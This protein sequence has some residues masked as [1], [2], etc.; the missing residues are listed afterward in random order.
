MLSFSTKRI[1]WYTVLSTIGLFSLPSA[2]LPYR[3][4][5]TPLTGRQAQGG[6]SS[7]QVLARNGEGDFEFYRIVALADLGDGVVLASYD[8][9]PDGA[10]SPSPNSILQ[11]RS[12]DGGESWGPPTYIAK[13]QPGD[14]A[15]GKQQ[16]GF[17]DTSSIGRQERSS[18]SMFSP[19]IGAST[20][21]PLGMMTRTWTSRALRSLSQR[22]EGSAGRRTQR[23]SRTY[24]LL[25]LKSRAR[26]L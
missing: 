25:P 3:D 4:S 5:L 17:S 19:R 24:P 9:R 1:L 18:I 21:A 11:R 13:G 8:G 16:Y 7:T 22:M 20:M 26:R 14:E 23:T 2:A 10:D 12:T 15:A 6:S